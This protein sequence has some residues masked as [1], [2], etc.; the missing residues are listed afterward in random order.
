[1]LAALVIL[2]MIS[3][4]SVWQQGTCRAQAVAA[5]DG[6]APLWLGRFSAQGTP[7]TMN[8][9]STIIGSAFVACIFLISKG[10]LAVFFSLTVSV[11]ISL[12]AM[13]YFFVFPSVIRLRKLYP[14]RQRPFRVPGG[15]VGLWICVIGSEFIIVLTTVTLL[16]PGLLNAVFGQ[17]Y[18][19]E[20]SW[21]VS[22][23]YFESVSLGIVA[24]FFLIAGVFLYLGSRNRKK[25]L[26]GE[27]DLLTLKIEAAQPAPSAGT[28]RG[29]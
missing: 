11:T 26:V 17:S 7:V 3:A 10:S 5:L 16:F 8:I 22:R 6:S 18:S 28:G 21:G 23:T 4:G 24:F 27:D 13:M 25:G 29:H 14:D 15:K 1:V 12:T 2:S 20:T 19:I 9:L